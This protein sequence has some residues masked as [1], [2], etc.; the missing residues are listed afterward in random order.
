MSPAKTNKQTIQ[1]GPSMRLVSLKVTGRAHHVV[2]RVRL[3]PR[4]SRTRERPLVM[5]G[6]RIICGGAGIHAVTAFG[7]SPPNCRESP[8]TGIC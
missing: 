6:H 7:A 3:T 8:G 2:S 4:E 5:R 1:V